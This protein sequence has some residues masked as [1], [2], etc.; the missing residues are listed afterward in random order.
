MSES[1][2]LICA[3]VTNGLAASAMITRFVLEDK[4]LIPYMTDSVLGAQSQ[5]EAGIANLM[6]QKERMQFDVSIMVFHLS[7][8]T[9]FSPGTFHHFLLPI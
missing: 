6:D 1:I 7:H 4:L 3:L 8:K 9:V 5:Q 2:S